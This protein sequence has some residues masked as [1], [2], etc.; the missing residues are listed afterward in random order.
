MT[1]HMIINM[2][3]K[4]MGPYVII[5]VQKLGATSKLTVFKNA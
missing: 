3:I 5:Q 2:S 1:L 4:M